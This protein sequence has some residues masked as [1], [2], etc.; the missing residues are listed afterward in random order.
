MWFFGFQ[1]KR[2]VAERYD[3]GYPGMVFATRKPNSHSA[4]TVPH[5]LIQPCSILAWNISAKP[6][7]SYSQPYYSSSSRPAMYTT[8]AQFYPAAYPPPPRYMSESQYG[9]NQRPPAPS[10]P[11]HPTS[12]RSASRF[13]QSS[14]VATGSGSS[15][16]SY[17]S[18]AGRPTP[19]SARRVTFGRV[20]VR[21]FG[22]G[23]RGVR[24]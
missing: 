4:T 19:A 17:A 22:G 18:Q 1:K 10:P 8:Q 2:K 12:T 9:Y 21:E 16:R 13:T 11:Y 7:N 24:T 23:R 5:W 6:A 15:A 14:S 3:A 20:E